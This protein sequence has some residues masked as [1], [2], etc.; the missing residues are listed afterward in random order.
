[1]DYVFTL[2]LVTLESVAAVMMHS[3]WLEW[4]KEK[5]QVVFAVILFA[6][7][8]FCFLYIY[9]GGMATRIFLTV[10][11]YIVWGLLFWRGSFISRLMVAVSYCAVAN[12]MDSLAVGI[13][14]VVSNKSDDLLGTPVLFLAGAG[15][16]KSLLILT[17]F[18]LYRMARYTQKRKRNARDCLLSLLPAVG[19][20][21]F[22]LLFC[23]YFLEY[24][25]V[26]EQLTMTVAFFSAVTFLY[27]AQKFAAE[28]ADQ[29]AELYK[30][31]QQVLVQQNK[32]QRAVLHDAANFSL[33]VGSLLE[34]GEQERALALVRQLTDRYSTATRLIHTDNPTVDAVLSDQCAKAAAQK[35]QLFVET[36]SLKNLVMKELDIV[37]VLSNLLDNARN[38]C[39][40]CE[41]PRRISIQAV[42]NGPEYVRLTVRNTCAPQ[43][44]AAPLPTTAGV[45]AHGY[46]QKN[47]QKVLSQYDCDCDFEQDGD[48]YRAIAILPC[49][50]DD[51]APFC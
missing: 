18:Y 20:L 39:M 21:L 49:P 2:M 50:C 22:S 34:N 30:N 47:V 11:R 38:A 29:R 7:L 13:L 26:S 36:C 16:S 31:Q 23:D 51:S 5:H 10:C 32:E 41:G 42:P 28:N 14:W 6:A 15:L 45:E 46:G 3:A 48:W 19:L 33:A 25:S 40:A 4:R 44:P 17:S 1:M 27:F 8:A 12:C 24:G 37:V 9:E 35:I 43:R